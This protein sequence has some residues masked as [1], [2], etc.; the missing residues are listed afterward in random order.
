LREYTVLSLGGGT[1]SS[2]LAIMA[3]NMNEIPTP[4]IAMFADTGWEPEGVYNVVEWLK[5]NLP[6]PVQTIP[7]RDLREDLMNNWDNYGRAANFNPLPMHSKTRGM[8][9]RQC[10]NWYKIQPLIQAQRRMVG[11]KRGQSMPWDVKV[12]V[13]IGISIDEYMRMKPSK[14]K[15]QHNTFPLID[16]SLTRGDCIEYWN[17][18]ARP[19]GAPPIA[20]SSCI[21]C[22]YHSGEQWATLTPEEID[23]V[24]EV[25]NHLL[26]YYGGDDR[27]TRLGVPVRKAVHIFRNKQASQ[28][29]SFEEEC[30]GHCGV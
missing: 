22:P 5:K 10:T 9:K 16:L 24:E 18:V 30:S 26:D 23:D 20:K 25:E 8:G 3:A 12:N 7:G 19:A 28:E 11:V 2:A 13:Q 21:G 14:L 15:W 27:L 4:D 6:Y 1:Q 29:S 17:S